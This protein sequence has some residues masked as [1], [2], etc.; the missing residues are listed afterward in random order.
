MSNDRQ[1][2]SIEI[3]PLRPAADSYDVAILGGG[4]AGLTLAIQLKKARPETSVV[5]LEKREGPAPLAAFK[6][7]E[8]T[9]PAGA[10]YFAK[11][12]GMETHLKQRQLI[13]FGLRFIMPSEDNSDITQ[14]IE[15]GPADFPPQDNYQVDRGLF[16]NELAA[17]VR[18]LGADVL[19]GCRVQ[20]VDLGSDNHIVTYTQSEAE[21]SL[22]ARWVVD[23]AGRASLL[24]RKLGLS[25]EIPHTINSAWLRLRGGLDFE[26]WG[27]DNPEWMAKMPEPG[28]RQYSTTHLLG[29]GYWVWLIPLSTGPISIGVCADPRLHPFEEINELDRMVDWLHRHEPQLGAAIDGRRGDIEDFLR[30][31][32]FAYGVDQ[33]YSAERWSLV[34]EAGA[35][36]D[37]FYSPGSDFIGYGNTFTTDLVTRD[38]QGEDI[39]ELVDYYN[40]YYQRTFA[41]VIAKYEDQYPTMGQPAVMMPKLLWDS[42]VNHGAQTMIMIQNRF[43]DPEFLKSVD[44][45]VDR[46]Y[47]L[48]INMQQLFRDWRDLEKEF[49][50]YPGGIGFLPLVQATFASA[51]PFDDDS[52]RA[53]LASREGSRGGDG[54]GHLPPRGQRCSLGGSGPRAARQSLRGEHASRALGGGRSLRRARANPRA[55]QVRDLAPR[56]ASGGRPPRP[57]ARNRR[58]TP[59]IGGP[60]PGIGGPPP[61]IGGPPPGIGGPPPGIGGPPPGIGGPPPGIGGPPPGIGGPP[62]GIGGPPPG[63]GGPPKPDQT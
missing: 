9:V 46:M 21:T 38:L 4:L 44:D 16:E 37:P 26:Q 57:A 59:G 41:Y 19:Q 34:G 58:P 63:V 13:K 22:Q 2:S 53:E 61:G 12:V 28:R 50:I 29:E 31:E 52:L 3:V 42:V 36:A 55:G 43:G 25:K 8:S 62:P 33:T 14:R 5:V 6:V 56:R 48:A 20:D 60:P 40:D 15:F 47:R 30:V 51:R 27:I 10:H 49:R 18:Y 35:F 7:G 1:A 45:D 11:V 54:R 39:A 32:D 24:K 17:R 23:A